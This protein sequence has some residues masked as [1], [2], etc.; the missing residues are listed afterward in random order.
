MAAVI[1]ESRRW[2]VLLAQNPYAARILGKAYAFLSRPIWVEGYP[3]NDVLTNGD[4]GATRAALGIRPDERVLLYAPTW[5]DDRTEMVDF[6]DPVAL[7]DATD[8]VVLVRGSLPHAASGA[9]CRGPARR[10]RHGLPRHVAAAAGR[11]CA[12]HRLLVGHVRLQR[13]RQADVLPR[14]R[15]R[16]LPRRAARLLLRSRRARAR[17]GRAHARTSSSRRCATAIRPRSPRSTRS[18]ARSS[19]RATTGTPPSGSSAGSSTRDSST[20]AVECAATAD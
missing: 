15:H 9:G 16:A 12:H 10:R 4:D 19:T 17:A 18:G 5:R 1:K 6:V 3:R 8:S 20:A 13:H 2:N 14:A 11:R 7:A